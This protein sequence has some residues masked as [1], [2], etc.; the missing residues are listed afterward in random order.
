MLMHAH[1]GAVDHLHVAVVSGCDGSQNAVPDPSSSPPHKAVVAGG[2]GAELLRQRPPRRARPQDPE[3]PV[4]NPPVV[5]PRHAARLVRKQRRDH[6]PL[7]IAQFVTPHDPAPPV[8][9]L[10]S[11]LPAKGNPLYEFMT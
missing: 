9:K 8:G 5:Y 4:Q 6:T 7:E 1:R 3:Y 10:E 11:Q 2:R